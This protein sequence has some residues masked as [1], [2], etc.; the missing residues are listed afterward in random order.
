MRTNIMLEISHVL[1]TPDRKLLH[2]HLIEET[3]D[4]APDYENAPCLFNDKEYAVNLIDTDADNDYKLS[5]HDIHLTRSNSINKNWA[6]DKGSFCLETRTSYYRR[7]IGRSKSLFLFEGI[8]GYVCFILKEKSGDKTKKYISDP[9][10]VYMSEGNYYRMTAEYIDRLEAEG[11]HDNPFTDIAD[12]ITM[13]TDVIEDDKLLFKTAWLLKE[14]TIEHEKQ[15]ELLLT[16]MYNMAS[17]LYNISEHS[18]PQMVQQQKKEVLIHDNNILFMGTKESYDAARGNLFSLRQRLAKY[19]ENTEKPAENENYFCMR[20]FDMA[21]KA[22]DKDLWTQLKDLAPDHTILLRPYAWVKEEVEAYFKELEKIFTIPQYKVSDKGRW[23]DGG[24]LLFNAFCY[25]EYVREAISLSIPGNTYTTVAQTTYDYGYVSSE[26]K[27]TDNNTIY[28]RTRTNNAR[29]DQRTVTFYYQPVIFYRPQPSD[30]K[31]LNV[32]TTNTVTINGQT[33]HINNKL[34]KTQLE[35]RLRLE[36]AEH[37]KLK[38]PGLD[39]TKITD[40]AYTPDF[41]IKVSKGEKSAYAILDAKFEQPER[42]FSVYTVLPPPANDSKDTAK[43]L[44]RKYMNYIRGDSNNII[45]GLTLV[46][47]RPDEHENYYISHYQKE[48]PGQAD[49][50]APDLSAI[51]KDYEE[52]VYSNRFVHGINLLSTRPYQGEQIGLYPIL[53]QENY[54]DF[55]QYIKSLLRKLEALVD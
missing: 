39:F 19:S 10:Y 31:P 32:V 51:S 49:L 4:Y 46:L 12:R 27:H 45:A 36:A 43:K 3:K 47:G 18:L 15:K 8:F 28:Y 1:H 2:F 41:I 22:G 44:I 50:T 9:V 38:V 21:F 55:T 16:C 20:F 35:Q 25:E 29:S 54:N 17:T 40:L 14:D 23:Y 30:P 26:Y 48:T 11:W 5:L 37:G 7:R 24:E 34:E 53:V 33:C 6:S 42:H 52:K 13:L